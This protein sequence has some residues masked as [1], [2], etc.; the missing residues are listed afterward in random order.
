M[1]DIPT[2]TL[3]FFEKHGKMMIGVGLLVGS[4]AFV[5]DTVNP[6]TVKAWAIAE[7]R[8]ACALTAFMNR[9]ETREC[10]RTS[11]SANEI[12]RCVK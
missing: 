10:I 2:K 12:Y 7:E 1:T 9:V 5:L 3:S 4:M 8:K 11:T 6:E